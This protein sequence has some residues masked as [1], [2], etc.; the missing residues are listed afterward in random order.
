MF[1]NV[2]LHEE[3]EPPETDKLEHSQKAVKSVP[4]SW[5]IAN[6]G[7]SVN[8]PEIDD[9]EISESFEENSQ[10]IIVISRS[11]RFFLA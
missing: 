10:V 11:L 1:D 6:A 4:V 3:P 8:R 2:T 9:N 5:T 7:K